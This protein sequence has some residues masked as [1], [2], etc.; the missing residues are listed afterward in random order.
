[1]TKELKAYLIDVLKAIEEIES[2]T[3]DLSFEEFSRNVVSVRVVAKDFA[4]IGG[5]AKHILSG[6]GGNSGQFSLWERL[7]FR[8]KGVPDCSRV[9]VDVLWRAVKSDLPILKSMVEGFL[10]DFG[11]E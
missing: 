7:G 8:D 9:K 2:V 11:G 3:D 5:A 10:D 4:L 1:M 6:N